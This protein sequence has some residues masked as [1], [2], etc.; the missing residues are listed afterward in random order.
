MDTDIAAIALGPL[1]L[2]RMTRADAAGWICAQ[3]KA[4]RSCVVVTSNIHHLRLAERDAAFRDVV[5]RAELNVA[6]GWPLVAASR[7]IRTPLPER[8]AGVDLVADVLQTSERLRLAVVGGASGAAER[9]AETIGDRHEVTLVDPLP[10]GTWETPGAQAALGSRLTTARPHVTLLGLGA[11]MQEL[12]ADRLRA[13]TSG[14]IICCGAA[15]EMLAGVRARA[16]RAVQSVG[17]EWAFRLALEPARLGP[18][19]ALSALT[20]LHVVAREL[21]RP[22]R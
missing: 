16:P 8:V 4:G 20:Y 18:R 13:A 22:P 7:A 1:E 17:L 12:L 9:L 5:S 14:P 19:Y 6:D 21:R 3:A 11:P 2:A 10:R 15:I